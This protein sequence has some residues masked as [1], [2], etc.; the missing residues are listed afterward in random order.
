MTRR[1][2]ATGRLRSRAN[3]GASDAC[4]PTMLEHQLMETRGG[5]GQPS[6]PLAVP[7]MVPHVSSMRRETNATSPPG[8]AISTGA[9][10]HAVAG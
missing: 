1:V 3:K 5:Q 6:P 7:L 10:E 9:P 2:R 4:L 8:Q